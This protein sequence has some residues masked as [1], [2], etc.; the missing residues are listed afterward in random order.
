MSDNFL[1]SQSWAAFQKQC[2]RKHWFIEAA[3]MR[4]LV[5]KYPLPLKKSYL[6]SP[7]GPMI[8]EGVADWPEFLQAIKKIAQQEKAIF[9]RCD[10]RIDLKLEDL[11]FQKAPKDYYFSATALPKETA[12]LDISVSEEEILKKMHPKTRYN[13][14]LAEQRGV[15]IKQ[16]RT[17]E[18]SEIFYNLI[19]KTAQREKIKPHPKEHYQKLLE[20]FDGSIEIFLGYYQ[21]QPIAGILVLFFGDT[22]IYLHGGFNSKY[23]N[24]MAP[25]LL[26]WLAIKEAKKRGCREYDFGGIS[27]ESDHPWSGITRFKLSFGAEPVIYPGAYD[28]I[29][30]PFWYWVY[31]LIR[32]L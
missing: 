28:L 2:G 12:V 1:Q 29:F 10:P 4:G 3:G 15:E 32:K 23:R 6:Y 21:N 16:S 14:H 30:Q 26:Q 17:T 25:H 19:Y 11:R 20:T 22:A 8:N 31:N 7:N 13:I 27:L 18:D 9:F 24:L 5:I